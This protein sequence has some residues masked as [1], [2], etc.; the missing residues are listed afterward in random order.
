[1][2]FAT[3]LSVLLLA[4]GCLTGDGAHVE[5]EVPVDVAP[6]ADNAEH[7]V[8]TPGGTVTVS[9]DENVTTGYTWV[10]ISDTDMVSV[11]IDHLGPR[12]GDGMTGS[13]GQARVTFA[14]DPRFN[15]R[16]TVTLL[17]QRPWNKETSQFR[18]Y[19]VTP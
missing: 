13:P 12:A 15:G 17:Y 4:A 18:V 5:S 3:I 6:C 1:M 14:A 7:I 10:G 9:L 16:A 11:T 2:K 19:T 8:I